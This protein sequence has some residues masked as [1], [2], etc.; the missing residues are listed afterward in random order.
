LNSNDIQINKIIK[1]RRYSIY[2]IIKKENG[3]YITSKKKRT[4]MNIVPIFKE[5]EIFVEEKGLCKKK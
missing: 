1:K 5:K 2:Q 3:L 4:N